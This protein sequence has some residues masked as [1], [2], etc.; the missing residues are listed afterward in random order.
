M[1]QLAGRKRL[2]GRAIGWSCV[3]SALPA[4]GFAQGT[5]TPLEEIV[6]TAT[7]IQKPLN[8]VPGAIS[9]IDQDVIQLG[10]QQLALDES[11]SRV[12][13]VFMQ[14][15][16]NFAQD[17]RVSIRGFG[18]R[19]NF[20]IRGV[21][22]VVDGIPETLPDGQG[23]FNTIDIGATS[24][25]EVLRG[26]SSSIWGNASG[27]VIS[28]TSERAPSDP[29]ME[30]RASAGEY[31]FRKVQFKT[32]SQGERVGY[33]FSVSDYDYDGYRN[34]SDAEKT[35]ATGRFNFDLGDGREL[36]SVVSYTDQ[37]VTD[38]PGGINAAQVALD[39]RSARD[40]NITFN[41]GETI[42][43]LR[44]GLV[45]T[46]P[47][48]GDDMISARTYYA[49][50]DFDNYLPF[51][52]GGSVNLER[53]FSGGGLSY[54]MNGMLG[55]ME[56]TLIIGVDFDDQDDDRLRFD[57]NDG[58]RGALTFDQNESV[59]SLG[60]FAKTTSSSASACC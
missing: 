50:R 26:P 56:N 49:T 35:Q 32:A 43:Q 19:A 59:R 23:N 57:N 33:L 11:L 46:T 52:A 53:T 15:R 34:Q 1:S 7:R 31:G 5:V 16:Y 8:R 47:V 54:T 6:V 51:V 24:Q 44:V 40:A 14:N 37:P 55:R 25:I 58:V 13:G 3:L 10:R 38:D 42:E 12:P 48:A 17:T 36:V 21:K 41:A 45:Y 60:I 18:A 39:R 2:F 27:G 30:V 28:V 20:G 9:V 4:I 22:I 29:F